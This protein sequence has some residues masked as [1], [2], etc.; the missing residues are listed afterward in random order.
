MNEVSI[1][2]GL[3]HPCIPTIYDIEEDKEY[4]Y[5]I[6]EFLQGVSLK[7]YR[8]S[9]KW[10]KDKEVLSLV[11]Q[12]CDVLSYLHNQ[13]GTILYLD[14]KPE[15]LM[16]DKNQIKLLDFGSA[17]C[18]QDKGRRGM[19]FGTK[20]YAAPEQLDGLSG[21]DER[22]DVYSIGALLFFLITGREYQKTEVSRQWAWMLLSNYRLYQIIEK[23][24]RENPSE[25]FL[26]MNQL[27]KELLRMQSKGDLQKQ[28]SAMSYQVAVAG[29][30]RR[31][32]TTH[33]SLRLSLY[34]AAVYRNA[35]YIEC[36]EQEVE[37]SIARY[38]QGKKRGKT[39]FSFFNVPS[40][41]MC[42]EKERYPF[43]IIDFG[44]LSEDNLNAFLGSTHRI[45]VLGTREWEMKQTFY[46]LKKLCDCEEI[47]YLANLPESGMFEK[48]SSLLEPERC[49]K[50]PFL[51]SW[52]NAG[53]SKEE[54]RVF[55]E[56]CSY[57][58][59][60][61]DWSCKA[62]FVFRLKR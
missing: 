23:C 10:M 8:M 59:R 12:V 7:S 40:W 28:A 29:C 62:K 31:M 48:L 44:E 9:R 41:E 47:L 61:S 14:L 56:V 34:L 54:K 1:L 45:V 39:R 25:R 21:V 37:Q 26:S 57:L 18:L 6:E 24:L 52:N 19:S 4:S 49:L 11:I 33:F 35:A 15:N 13:E 17:L 55:D 42:E 16:Y 50:L 58:T 3:N 36:N 53:I 43:Q 5:I 38:G 51:R 2:K 60:T 30:G 20:G 46:W 32:G 22:S 27:K